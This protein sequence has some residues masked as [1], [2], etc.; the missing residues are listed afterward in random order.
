MKLLIDSP[1]L[2]TRLSI[3]SSGLPGKQLHCWVL[4]RALLHWDAR[5]AVAGP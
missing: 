1:Q 2:P 5:S 4:P 3:S